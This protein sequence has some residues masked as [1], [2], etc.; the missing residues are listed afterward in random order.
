[1]NFGAM[2]AVAMAI[3]IGLGA[4]GAHGL[5]AQLSPEALSWWEIGVRYQVWHALGLIALAL[6][7][8]HG[9]PTWRRRSGIAFL[10]GILIFSGSLYTLAL[11]GPRFLGAVTPIG[12]LSFIVGWISFALAFIAAARSDPDG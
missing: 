7:T 11:G 12:G 2:G 10:I 8:D 9:H 5:K 3:A 1:M 6:M 4:F